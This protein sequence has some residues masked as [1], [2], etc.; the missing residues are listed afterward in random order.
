M[1]GGKRRRFEA[2]LADTA[3]DSD[4]DS[5]AAGASEEAADDDDE[6]EQQQ[7]QQQQEQQDSRLKKLH[8]AATSLKG[9]GGGA[10][11]H[12]SQLLCCVWRG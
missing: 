12:V 10:V 2:V 1:P 3:A 9:K 6:D 11:C 8:V 4:A 7:Q 5:D